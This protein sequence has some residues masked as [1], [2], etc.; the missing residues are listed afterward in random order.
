LGVG[1]LLGVELGAVDG[2]VLGVELGE[3]DGIVL[4]TELGTVDPEGALLGVSQ[5][6]QSG[7]SHFPS[8]S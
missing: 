6:A 4:G 3:V 1:A 8:S 7:P 2:A 5:F